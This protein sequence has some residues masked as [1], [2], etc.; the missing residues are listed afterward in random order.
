MLDGDG[1]DI[2]EFQYGAQGRV[3]IQDVIER[4]FFTLKLFGLGD[5]RAGVAFGAVK[6]RAL[7]RVFAVAHVLEFVDLNLTFVPQRCGFLFSSSE[8]K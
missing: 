7:M 1:R 2:G 5:G 3:G 8:E 4:Q 6:R